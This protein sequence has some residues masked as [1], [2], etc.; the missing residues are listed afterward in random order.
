MTRVS[1]GFQAGLSRSQTGAL[2]RMIVRWS[3]IDHIV[4]SCVLILRGRPRRKVREKID[5]CPAG[6]KLRELTT[7]MATS[8]VSAEARAAYD[9]FVPLWRALIGVRN[10]VAHGVASWDPEGRVNTT[11]TFRGRRIAIK[12]VIAAEAIMNYA[13]NAVMVFRMA[14]GKEGDAHPRQRLLRRPTIPTIVSVYMNERDGGL[15]DG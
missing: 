14:I 4:S 1:G 3:Q 13:A 10:H 12:D 9:E 7:L 6:Q 8:A 15:T 5:N 2:G 11:L